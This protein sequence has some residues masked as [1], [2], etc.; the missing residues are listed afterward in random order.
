M[1]AFFV[2]DVLFGWFVYVKKKW[3]NSGK[4]FVV[5]NGNTSNIKSTLD[6]IYKEK[7]ISVYCIYWP[8]NSLK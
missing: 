8:D 1:D 4:Y 7:S 6:T 5:F 3:M 2:G